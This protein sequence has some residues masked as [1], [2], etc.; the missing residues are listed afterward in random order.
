MKKLAHETLDH[1][2]IKTLLTSITSDY[3]DY[4]YFEDGTSTT[5]I[6]NT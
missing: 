3:L 2:S 4:F 6:K 1:S 5:D